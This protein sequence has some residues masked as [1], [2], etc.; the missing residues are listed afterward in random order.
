[1]LKALISLGSLGFVLSTILSIAYA[2][3][4]IKVSQKEKEILDALPGA[5]C[6]ACGFPGCEGYGSALSKGEVEIGF[7]PVG[8]ADLSSKL[9]EILGVESKKVEPKVAAMR[10][11]GGIN[12]TTERFNY[13][14]L[15]NCA[16]A[17]LVSGGPKSCFYGC[18]GFGDC[19][20]ACKFDA[21]KIGDKGL[22]V[23]D[24]KKCTGCGLC[25]DACPQHIID[26]LPKIEKIYVSCNSPA[27][28]KLTKLSC[29]VGCIGCKICER[30]C[31]YNAIKVENR[32][33]RIN[34]ELCKNCGICVKKCPTGAIV[35][36]LNSRP[37]AM[38][39]IDCTGCEKCKE[40]CLMKAISGEP[41]KQHRVDFNKCVGCALCTKVC[42]SE[43]IT[44][45]F[46]LG[47]STVN[48]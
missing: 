25:S 48:N 16:G 26:L 38:I 9:S 45:A 7:C 3:L 14:G 21:I 42:E 12:N 13:V 23:I 35:D 43:A 37:K 8:G 22:P 34:F 11:N 30:N 17:R 27:S 29:K 33:A 15:K 47:Y 24:D 32:M 39:G 36:K 5:N 40:V 20:L 28:A 2:K 44:M 31:P 41:N 19:V 18:L 10:C 4:A 46:S 6:G 1:M